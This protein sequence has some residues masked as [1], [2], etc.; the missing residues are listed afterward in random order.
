LYKTA[1]GTDSYDGVESM[2][3]SM[4]STHFAKPDDQAMRSR[5][6]VLALEEASAGPGAIAQRKGDVP[7]AMVTAART[8]GAVYRVHLPSYL[9]RVWAS[10]DHAG[11]PVAWRHRVA[12]TVRFPRGERAFE[13]EIRAVDG[14]AGIPY[15][16]PN[17]L[18]EHVGAESPGVHARTWNGAGLAENAFTV[19][20]F[21]DELAAL[22]GSCPVHYR[23]RM[24]A[25]SP[26]AL[27]VLELAVS[28]SAWDSPLDHGTGRGLAMQAAR[29]SFLALVAEVEVFGRDVHV[30]RVTCAIECGPAAD[31]RAARRQVE[32]GVLLG[33]ESA[34]GRIDGHR[35][36]PNE[37]PAI[38][39]HFTD[40]P[41]DSEGIA[42]IAA[43]A[44]APAVANAIFNATGNR[45]RTLP[46]VAT[47][48]EIS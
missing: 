7:R 12:S 43:A 39:V 8:H 46:L 19:E 41:G 10:L 1:N 11:I 28:R 42:E 24:L 25:D 15:A 21:V 29:Q 40:G 13:D 38:D 17:I 35:A 27:A 4:I 47:P 22:S 18:V 37:A 20:S 33:L 44:I 23:R 2:R 31:P 48:K 3:F 32:A 30:G 5:E 14:A 36:P 16:I 26:R 6:F 34:L 45:I 9:G